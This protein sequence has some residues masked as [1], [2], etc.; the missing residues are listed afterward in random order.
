M[1]LSLQS[2]YN[3][4][5]GQSWSI[6]ETNIIDF[7]E[8]EKSVI[9]AIQKALRMLWN[10]HPYSFRLKNRSIKLVPNLERYS[11]PDGNIVQNGVKL[12]DTQEILKPKM[13]KDILG[14]E[15]GKPKYFYIKYNKLFFY[16][17][18]DKEYSV[19]IDHNTFKMGVNE[20]GE[21]LY[22][23]S[24]PTDSL[25]IPE[26]YEDLFLH[27][28]MNKSMLNALTS[29]KSELFQPYLAQFV[30]S[31]RNLVTKTSGLDTEMEIR[32]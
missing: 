22:N 9:I 12:I 3:Q 19:S 4:V 18:P 26:I 31:Y 25:N 7:D 30:E 17:T 2:I 24:K 15:V 10:A 32:W 28:L 21:S 5:T 29:G 14:N 11:R 6:Y 16:P 23:L 13:Y 27:A 1:S 8:A 20:K